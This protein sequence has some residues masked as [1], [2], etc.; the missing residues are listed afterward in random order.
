MCRRVSCVSVL[1]IITMSDINYYS[2]AKYASSSDREAISYATQADILVVARDSAI[3][4]TVVSCTSPLC[5]AC[6]WQAATRSE[7]RDEVD[8][9]RGSPSAFGSRCRRVLLLNIKP[10][11]CQRLRYSSKAAH[12]AGQAKQ[13]GRESGREGGQEESAR[14]AGG[15][16]QQADA[17]QA[18]VDAKPA[19]SMAPDEND[20]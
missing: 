3:H 19:P 2:S 9:E 5:S 17:A 20:V 7:C 15:E 4:L 12:C 18:L 1:I 10:V 16:G 6:R 14:G 11:N 8:K 13:G